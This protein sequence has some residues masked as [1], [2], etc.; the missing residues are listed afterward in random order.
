MPTA[1]VSTAEFAKKIEEFKSLVDKRVRKYVIEVHREIAMALVAATPMDSGQMQ[2]SWFAGRNTYP[3]GT[4]GNGGL[5]ALQWVAS[6]MK[7]GDNI[8]MANLAPYAW[9]VEYGTAAHVIE[10]RNASV[11]RWIGD[12]GRPAYA[13]RVNHPGTRPA[14]FIRDTLMRMP[15]FTQR[16]VALC[17]EVK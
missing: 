17:Q 5:Q 16:A 10:P 15:E 14:F 11:L 13:M 9:F 3:T 7:V 12:D 1:Q 4:P 6:Q 2:K 8:I